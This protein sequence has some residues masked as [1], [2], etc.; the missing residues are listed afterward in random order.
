VAE[1]SALATP[2]RQGRRLPFSVRPRP[3]P[4]I[5]RTPSAPLM[6]K[7]LGRGVSVLAV[8]LL[9]ACSR[10][11]SSG[12][13]DRRV[14]EDAYVVQRLVKTGGRSRVIDQAE[15][16]DLMCHLAGL[17]VSAGYDFFV[18]GPPGFHP[19]LTA[20]ADQTVEVATIRMF[21]GHPSPDNHSQI[22]AR[23]LKRQ[24]C[25]GG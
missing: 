17:T 5:Q 1:R 18:P 7:P 3:N 25:G 15:S 22:E 16:R 10:A 8:A 2:R 9:A 13:V 6:R 12:Y 4:R 20:G 19:D 24:L 14:A 21:K 23:V 11:Q